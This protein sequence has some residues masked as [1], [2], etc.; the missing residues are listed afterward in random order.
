MIVDM[1]RGSNAGATA[2]FP[3]P[4]ATTVRLDGIR[5]LNSEGLGK[6]NSQM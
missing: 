4:T 5:T 6:K 1:G 3:Q 2:E